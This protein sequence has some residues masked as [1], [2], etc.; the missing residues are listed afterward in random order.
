M[1]A[2]RQKT[3][4]PGAWSYAPEEALDE[5]D[6]GREGLSEDEAKRR[7]S[8]DGPNTIRGDGYLN[9]SRILLN[10]FSSP[11]IFILIG[12]SVLTAILR[13]WVDTAVILLAVFV[14][15]G[16]GY[17]QEYRAEDTLQ[18]L[19]AYIKDRSRIVR[20]GREV[21]ID[22]ADIVPGDIVRLAY[23]GRVPADCRIISSRDLTIDESIL[24][25]ESLPVSKSVNA[26]SVET[27]VPDRTNMAHAGTLV[28]EGYATAVAVGTGGKTELGRIAEMVSKTRGEKT[29]LQRALSVVAWVIF[30]GVIVIVIGIFALGL[31][32]GE[33]LLS[34]LL[35]SSAVAAGAVPEALPI[36]LTVILATGAGRIAKRNG[37]TRNLAAAETLGSAT[38]IMTDKTGTLTKADMRLTAI[39]PFERL[40]KASGMETGGFSDEERGVL[41]SAL[42]AVDVIIENEEDE[43]GS[44]R[45]RGRAL[46]TN[47]AKAAME[48]GLPVAEILREKNQ[49][50][51]P[52]NSTNK[53]SVVENRKAGTLT[54]LGAPD[55]LLRHSALSDTERADILARIDRDSSEGSRLV[56]VAEVRGTTA[57]RVLSGKEDPDRISGATFVGLLLFK[58]PL[59]IEAAP[60][61]RRMEEYGVRVIMLTGDLPGTALSVAKEIGWDVKPGE[62]I[63]GEE[64]GGMTDDELA[65]H[66]KTMRVFARVTPEDKMRVGRLLRSQGEVVAMT[67]DGVNDAPSLK[68]VD[69]GIALGAGSD[70]AKSAADLVLL[71]DNFKTIVAAIEEGRRILA[72]VRKTFVYLM[73]TTLDEII[74]IGG[75]IAIGLPLPLS[76]LQIIWVNFFTESFPALS[77]AFDQNHERGARNGGQRKNN[78]LNDEVKM[79]TVGIG[80]VTSA[81][82]FVLY[83]GLLEYGVPLPEAR[84]LLFVCFASYILAAAFPLRSLTEP[85]FS[86]PLFENRFLTVS[87]VLGFAFIISTVTVP[88]LKEIF[89]VVTPPFELLW[90]PFVW[91]A[92]NIAILEAAKW[93]FRT[94]ARN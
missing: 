71:D 55:V 53:F 50:V 8:E 14:N 81:L 78:I 25:G 75:S 61:I 42:R 27:P 77:Y 80:T 20:G 46:E 12:A 6:S 39:L 24:T 91:I 69:I 87:T 31:M 64:M 51:L 89:G 21:E 30:A 58:D 15:T 2:M 76:A 29:P 73:S 16:L 88:A 83:W 54:L 48:R 28:V 37:I 85:L 70:V 79:L 5:F 26:V 40:V 23:G 92:F 57:E 84:S 90:I 93:S 43:S 11:L 74:L 22:S 18:K 33:P 45:F 63:T 47:I 60:A 1:N 59:R 19:V 41:E 17:Y 68:A 52:F 3:E 72:N 38:V 66:L 67:G 94:L 32:R 49:H 86:Y 36:A 7:L 56:G 44:W 35:I 62:S 9:P 13:E 4:R 10:Q 82:L 65:P 34:M